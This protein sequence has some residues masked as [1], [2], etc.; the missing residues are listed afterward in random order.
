ML[1][2]IKVMLDFIQASQVMPLQVV[3]SNKLNKLGWV[4]RVSMGLG[5]RNTYQEMLEQKLTT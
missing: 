1:R 3:N 5:L 4:T 2:I